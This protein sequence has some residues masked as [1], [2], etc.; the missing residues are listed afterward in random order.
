MSPSLLLSRPLKLIKFVLSFLAPKA[1]RE[2]F[3]LCNIPCLTRESIT[4]FPHGIS[5]GPKVKVEFLVASADFSAFFKQRNEYWEVRQR[6]WI[7]SAVLT[8]VSWDSAQCL[9]REG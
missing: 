8:L 9:P 6:A 7:I 1:E 5:L 2:L 3:G 4:V